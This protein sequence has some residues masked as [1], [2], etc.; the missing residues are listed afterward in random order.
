MR[1]KAAAAIPG[2]AALRLA[3]LAAVA[4]IAALVT[5]LA[6]SPRL[7][8]SSPGFELTDLP[9]ALAKAAA[10]RACWGRWLQPGLPKTPISWEVF[11]ERSSFQTARV[12]Q[13]PP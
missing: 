8:P 1:P 13:E 10:L 4:P 5:P 12:P 2:A 9:P 7:R 3:L 11:D 6:R